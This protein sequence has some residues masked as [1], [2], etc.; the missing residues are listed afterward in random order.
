MV[1]SEAKGIAKRQLYLALLEMHYVDLTS[2][3]L[4]IMAL[5]AKDRQVQEYLQRVLRAEAEEADDA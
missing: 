3:E 5:L 4:D 2:G 1:M